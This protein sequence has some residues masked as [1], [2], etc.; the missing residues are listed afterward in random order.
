MKGLLFVLV[1]SLVAVGNALAQV[2]VTPNPNY[3][4]MIASADP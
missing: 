3:E 4:Q 1:A 2:P